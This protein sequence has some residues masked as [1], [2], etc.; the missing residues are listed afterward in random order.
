MRRHQG[1]RQKAARDH[2]HGARL[3]GSKALPGIL[4]PLD[5]ARRRRAILAARRTGRGEWYAVV[6]AFRREDEHVER[7]IAEAHARAGSQREAVEAGRRLVAEKANWLGPD[8]R[9]HVV[10][11][12]ALEWQ[13]AEE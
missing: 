7:V 4:R 3:F 11:Y 10:I 2:V 8:T 9:L 12:S 1:P 13:P 6:T 5:H